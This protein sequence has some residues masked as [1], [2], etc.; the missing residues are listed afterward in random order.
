V[1]SFLSFR[2]NVFYC[3]SPALHNIF[4]AYV[5]QYS[6]FVLK[7]PLNTNQPTLPNFVKIG[8]IVC[9]SIPANKQTIAG[10]NITSLSE[11]E[12]ITRYLK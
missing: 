3:L 6:V 7:V 10:E 9:L 5:I 11:S 12:V 1:K 8:S 4:H 2:F